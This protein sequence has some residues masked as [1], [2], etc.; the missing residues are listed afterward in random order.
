[1]DR[2]API[3]RLESVVLCVVSA[4]VG[5][6]FLAWVYKSHRNLPGLH[7]TGLR[8]SP[9]I[10]TMACMIPGVNL[11]AVYPVLVEIWRNSDPSGHPRCGRDVRGS[12]VWL[13]RL[14]YGLALICLLLSAGLLWTNVG[15]QSMRSAEVLRNARYVQFILLGTSVPPQLLFFF[16][17]WRIDRNQLER[18]RIP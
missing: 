9:A 18:N 13:V 6:A 10:A 14:W 1:M 4:I 5:L 16:V 17:S 12:S 2:L 8:F 11:L 3:L 15:S 7:A